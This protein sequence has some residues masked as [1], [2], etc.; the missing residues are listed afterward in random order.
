MENIVNLQMMPGNMPADTQTRSAQRTDSGDEF[1][2][3]LQQKQETSEAKPKADEPVKTV[4]GEKTGDREEAKEEPAEEEVLTEDAQR[5]IL[6]LTAQQAAVQ[7]TVVIPSAE[8][9]PVQMEIQAEAAAVTGEIPVEPQ[10]KEPEAAIPEV[11]NDV[12]MPEKTQ[13]P[14]ETPKDLTP[15]AVVQEVKPEETR[16]ESFTSNGEAQSDRKSTVSEDVV[17]VH[18]T[19]VRTSEEVTADYEEKPEITAAPADQSPVLHQTTDSHEPA[20]GTEETVMKTTVEELPQKLGKELLSGQ[21]T[22]A[23][24]LTVELEPVSLGKLTIRVEY[25]AGRAAVSIIASNP[26]TLEL[27]N[28]KVSEIASILKE[29]TGEETVIYTQE[30]QRQEAEQYDGHQGGNRREQ[31]EQKQHKEEE[32][33]QS[34][35]FTQQLRLGLV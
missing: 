10:A 3:M 35:S 19:V 14:K 20:K 16:Q 17:P 9:Q 34:E 26:K 2:R 24:T 31:G 8:E 18:E 1:L 15:Q 13:M 23:R 32:R 7:N 12:Q 25:E 6:E 11:L 22:E 27:L 33:Q 30:S 5:L 21:T 4:K 29:H 28:Q